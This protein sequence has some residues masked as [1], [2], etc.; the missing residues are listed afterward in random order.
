MPSPFAIPRPTTVT[1][2]VGHQIDVGPP[3]AN[4]TDEQVSEQP[5]SDAGTFANTLNHSA[6]TQTRRI[7]RVPFTVQVSAV[8]EEYVTELCRLF[9]CNAPQ[10]LPKSVADRGIRI[11]RIGC[12]VVREA[13][14]AGASNAARMPEVAGRT[15][16]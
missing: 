3:N 4:P 12:G 15:T 5:N 9:T 7:M 8:F 2:V 6:A 14:C 13:F 16:Q 10:Y 11:E 1:F